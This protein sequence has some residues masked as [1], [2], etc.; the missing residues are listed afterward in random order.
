MKALID[1][2]SLLYK[3]GFALEDKVLWNEMEVLSGLEQELDVDYFTNIEQ[4]YRTFDQFVDNILFATDCDNAVLVFSGQG[5]FRL[6]FPIDY[7]TNR[8]DSRKPLG[9]EELLEYARSKYDTITPH[10]IEADDL[11]VW[12]KTAYPEDYILCAIDKDVLYQTVGVHYNYGRDEEVYVDEWAATKFAYVQTLTGDT[13]DGYKGCK[14]IGAVKAEKILA[15]C[16][17]E[18]DLWRAVVEAYESKGQTEEDALWTMRLANMKQFNGTE[19]VLWE[20]PT[21]NV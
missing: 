12:R 21:E 20:P 3:V 13:S 4:C 15:D 2:D 17:T 11:V 9:Y 18:Y 19:V 6:D 7:K 16:D 8:K 10:G 14:G 1:A 5:N